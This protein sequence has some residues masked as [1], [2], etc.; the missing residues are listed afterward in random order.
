MK[1]GLCLVARNEELHVVATLQSAQK[2]VQKVYFLDN[3]S[4]DHTRL[5][6]Q[7]WSESSGVPISISDEP[8]V[9]GSLDHLYARVLAEAAA[10]GCDW[11]L[12]LGADEELTFSARSRIPDLVRVAGVDAYK[13]P[14]LTVIRDY[15]SPS[16]GGEF[17]EGRESY[18]CDFRLFRA[19]AV[20]FPVAPEG[21]RPHG[22]ARVKELPD[23][24]IFVKQSRSGWEQLKADKER[25]E[26][27]ETPLPEFWETIGGWF[28]FQKA[29]DLAVS[30]APASGVLVEVGVYLGKSLIYLGQKAKE[31]GK[32]LQVVG[33][34]CFNMAPCKYHHPEIQKVAHHWLPVTAGNVAEAGLADTVRLVQWDS[35]ASA[36][37]FPDASVDFCF[38][39]AGHD[40]RTVRSDI[41]AW[42]PK[43]K[44]GGLIGGHDY[45]VEWEGVRQAVHEFSEQFEVELDLE[46]CS[47][48]WLA[49]KPHSYVI[50]K[51]MGG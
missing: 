47:G 27:P 33:V 21:L 13:A 35:A 10:D 8:I 7:N 36:A 46:T 40:Y 38:L 29:Y 50:D 39:D 30:E 31:S 6:A 17:L 41:R 12:L 51:Y 25:G 20:E 48:S 22:G 11:I 28:D 32:P 16:V 23:T 15:R 45:A 44:P 49:R 19:G 34:D 9:V 5:L 26:Y 14:C 18:Y 37:L 42:W 3:A 24:P 4:T 2:L 1:I 43:V